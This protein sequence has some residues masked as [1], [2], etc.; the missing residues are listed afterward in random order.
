MQWVVGV[1]ERGGGGGGGRAVSKV[2]IFHADISLAIWVEL[3]MEGLA[4]CAQRNRAWVSLLFL[5][6]GE[7]LD[8]TAHKNVIQD[9]FAFL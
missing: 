3:K 2:Q 9:R 8:S 6:D 1:V 5:L 4:K 7:T